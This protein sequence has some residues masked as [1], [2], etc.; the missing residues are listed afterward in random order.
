MISAKPTIINSHS[1]LLKLSEKQFEF[2]KRVG[3][4]GVK[5]NMYEY[6]Y[7]SD[8]FSA[9]DKFI[10]KTAALIQEINYKFDKVQM[11]FFLIQE[12]PYDFVIDAP[13]IEGEFFEY[14][15]EAYLNH[16]IGLFERI[17][18]ATNFL[19]DLRVNDRRIHDVIKKVTDVPLRNLLINLDY[20][21]RGMRKS[22]NVVVHEYRFSV[23]GLDYLIAKDIILRGKILDK[24]DNELDDSDIN[25]L[26]SLKKKYT[27]TLNKIFKEM[28]RTDNIITQNYYKILNIFEKQ[29]GNQLGI[30][31]DKK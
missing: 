10:A 14:H 3:D 29:Y 27:A 24:K 5:E 30:G 25:S 17:L 15:M 19:F 1:F 4:L 7:K 26:L 13:V 23:D 8:L 21:L 22:R 28:I 11:A 9:D 12:F 2:L 20:G 16:L 6:I 18:K 31:V